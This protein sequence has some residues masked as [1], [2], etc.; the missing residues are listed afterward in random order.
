MKAAHLALVLFGLTRAP[1][2]RGETLYAFVPASLG[3][4]VTG[5]L[6]V[7]DGPDDRVVTLVGSDASARPAAP[8]PHPVFVVEVPPQPAE[9]N[10][11]T[12]EG[13]A[14]YA[15]ALWPDTQGRIEVPPSDS[16][17]AS[18]ARRNPWEPVA[19]AH[20]SA[21]EMRFLC[22]GTIL[23]G[24]GGGVALINGRV[25]RRGDALGSY[26]VAQVLPGAVLL[27]CKGSL[28]GL[29]RGRAVTISSP[30]A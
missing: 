21:E 14:S 10:P 24:A 19:R 8:V 27:E 6:A 25:C 26:R 28:F 16:P 12:S 13:P 15:A 2:L 22:G 23:G 4:R 9:A 1:L 7:P 29:P 20:R 11:L 3:A 17:A 5:T 18:G 30:G